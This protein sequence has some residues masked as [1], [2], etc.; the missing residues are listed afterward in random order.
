MGQIGLPRIFRLIGWVMEA[1]LPQSD[2]VSG[3]CAA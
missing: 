3:P 1:G 2:A